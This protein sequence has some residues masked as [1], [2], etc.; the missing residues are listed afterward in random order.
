MSVSSVVL[1]G[2]ELAVTESVALGPGTRRDDQGAAYST[3]AGV[4][5]GREGQKIW[6][7]F[8][9]KRVGSQVYTYLYTVDSVI[10]VLVISS[11]CGR[12]RGTCGRSGSEDWESA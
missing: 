3:V 7:D 1:P 11:V 5:R 6:V 2:D 4:V 8:N 9:T 10:S 12:E